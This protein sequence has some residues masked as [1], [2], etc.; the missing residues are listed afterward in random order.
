MKKVKLDLEALAVE[1]FATADGGT[2]RGTVRGFWTETCVGIDL[3]CG[4]Q[5]QTYVESCAQGCGPDSYLQP[6]S[7][8]SA[9][10]PTVQPLTGG[11]TETI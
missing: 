8:P 7:E 5:N 9:T 3:P 2:G 4:S 10:R 6:C 11:G 1:S